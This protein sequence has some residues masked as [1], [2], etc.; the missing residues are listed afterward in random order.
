VD[1]RAQIY[2]WT[3]NQIWTPKRS[4]QYQLWDEET[5]QCI[6]AAVQE[7]TVCLLIRD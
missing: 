6:S 4:N 3:H 1:W 5:A 7:T 2:T